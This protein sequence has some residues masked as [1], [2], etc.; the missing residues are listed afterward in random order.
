MNDEI[1]DIKAA[2]K[3]AEAEILAKSLIESSKVSGN[4]EA[5]EGASAEQLHV[6]KRGIENEHDDQ[7]MKYACAFAAEHNLMPYSDHGSILHEYISDK[8]GNFETHT[9]GVTRKR[10]VLACTNGKMVWVD[11]QK[12]YKYYKI[13]VKDLLGRKVASYLYSKAEIQEILDKNILDVSRERAIEI[14][15]IEIAG[16][17]R[18]SLAMEYR[19]LR[20]EAKYIQGN[21]RSKNNYRLAIIKSRLSQS[22]KE[23]IDEVFV[24]SE[25]IGRKFYTFLVESSYH[26]GEISLPLLWIT[27][28]CVLSRFTFIWKVK[29]LVMKEIEF[30]RQDSPYDPLYSSW[31]DKTA[32]IS[33]YLIEQINRTKMVPERSYKPPRLVK[34][35]QNK[36]L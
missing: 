30:E 27:K 8:D 12:D 22:L 17:S 3:I 25:N 33:A 16:L 4:N 35:L 36:E 29:E 6:H 9:N 28:V 34:L 21:V 26:K 11:E 23:L 14:F 2:N 31:I 32:E 13:N 19:Q 18:T 10:S 24:T 15:G 5:M 7:R 1:P 20:E